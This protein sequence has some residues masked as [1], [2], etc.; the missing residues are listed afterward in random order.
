MS[1]SDATCPPTL[2]AARMLAVWRWISYTFSWAAGSYV[3]CLREAFDDVGGFDQRFYASEE[4][5]FSRSLKK[6]G[7]PRKMTMKILDQPLITS[8]RKLQWFT[9]GQAL[10]AMIALTLRPWRLRTQE[11]CWFW[12]E[13]PSEP[14]EK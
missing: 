13:R 14:E 11:G 4:I 7:K 10:R 12:Y 6:W 9:V 8:D 5:H 1:V 2:M 3:F